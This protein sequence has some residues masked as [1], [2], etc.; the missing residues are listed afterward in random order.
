MMMKQVPGCKLVGENSY[1][2]S[3]NPK[4]ATLSNG[5]TVYLPSWKSMTPGGELFEGVGIAPDI[6]VKM[7]ATD[8]MSRDP[9]LDAA[10]KLLRQ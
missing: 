7:T 4:A 8:F 1:G 10:L 9:V 3:G 5:V 2:S 6:E